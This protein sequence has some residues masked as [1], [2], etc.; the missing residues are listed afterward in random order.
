MTTLRRTSKTRAAAVGLALLVAALVDRAAAQVPPAGD[1]RHG[2]VFYVDGAGGGGALV[3]WSPGVFSGLRQ[4]GFDGTFSEFVWQTG[5]GIGFDHVSSVAYKRSKARELAEQVTAYRQTEPD[6]PIDIIA[7]SAGTAVATYALEALPPE[8]AVDDV[9]FL[10]PS[11]SA[12]YDLTAALRRLRG[13]LH[14][15][16]SSNDAML[17][18]M[19]P[20]AGTA[21]RRFCGHAVAG[22]TGFE[23]RTGDDAE[24]VLLYEKVQTVFWNPGFASS[25]YY[26]GH[27]DVASARF[28]CKYVAPVLRTDPGLAFA[29]ASSA[30]VTPAWA[31]N[32]HVNRPPTL[33]REALRR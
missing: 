7:L 33:D 13:H 15:F 24:S 27:T 12:Q 19:V 9:V 25:G 28:V 14:V 2:R 8:C 21:D 1:D 6:S 18:L 20:L 17:G 10:S 30:V 11:L 23:L 16:A 22:L 31:S 29:T 3:N 4:A 26:G 32:L 5:L